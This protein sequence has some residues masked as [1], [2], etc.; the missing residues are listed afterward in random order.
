MSAA[1]DVVTVNVVVSASGPSRQGFGIPLVAGFHTYYTDFVRAYSSPQGLTADGFLVTD[2]IY[3]AVSKFFSQTPAVGTV[4]VGRR[5]HSFVQT[6][7][8]TLLSTVTTDVYRV[9]AGLPGTAPQTVTFTSTGVPA[10]D[11]TTMAT[12][13][14]ALGIT[15]LTVTHS[16]AVVTLTMAAGKLVDFFPDLLHTSF[17]DVT[18]SLA[19]NLAADLNTIL[20]VNPNF[21]GVVLDS[22][23]PNEIT[24]GATWALA[25]GK[26]FGTNA[27]DTAIMNAASTTD[28]AF[29]S[30]ASNNSYLFGLLSA[31]HVLSY[32][33]AGWMGVLFPTDAG[34]ENW[35]FKTIQGV[36]ADV[37]TTTQ[38]H[39]AEGKSWNTYSSILG[40]PLTRFGKTCSTS[41]PFIDLRR[42]TDW[43]ANTIQATIIGLLA[44]N[45]KIAFTDKGLQTIAGGI[46]GV[47]QQGVQR[48]FLAANPAP[49]V[50]VP[51]VATISALDRANRNIPGISATATL[52][53][54][55]NTVTF[56]IALSS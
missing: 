10:T 5:Q 20:A 50:T 13:L 48:G 28:I 3:Q 32:S 8:V 22:N 2:G 34:S 19:G 33:A 52:A 11:A 55:V 38:L 15:G 53:G 14:T 42:G 43:L 4:L 37:L 51:L 23:S 17:A 35:S 56:N 29:T 36:T 16:S 12:A 24:E 39:G 40:L 7:N 41:L 6:L 45:L 30:G 25:N 27:T 1:S 44:N 31:A 54:A 26:L 49:V 9:Q 18:P 47:L 21:Y 46:M